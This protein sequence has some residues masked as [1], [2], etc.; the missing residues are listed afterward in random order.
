[1]SK[2]LVRMRSTPIRWIP[3]TISPLVGVIS[4]PT[5][6]RSPLT[7]AS[8][9][10]GPTCTPFPPGKRHRKCRRNPAETCSDESQGT[11][12]HMPG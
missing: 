9:H 1:M 6:M 11:R 4:P 10:P 5:D 12:E 8:S 3:D 7:G 2:P